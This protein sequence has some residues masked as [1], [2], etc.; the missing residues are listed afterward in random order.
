MPNFYKGDNMG[1]AQ[2]SSAQKSSKAQPNSV[3]AGKLS[4][5]SN[6]MDGTHSGKESHNSSHG[7]SHHSGY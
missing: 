7:T 4:G 1:K 6:F 2:P 3:N 5:T